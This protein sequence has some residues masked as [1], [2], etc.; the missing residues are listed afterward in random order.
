LV[1]T[2]SI[3]DAIGPVDYSRIEIKF[4]S[5]PKV[6]DSLLLAELSITCGLEVSMSNLEDNRRIISVRGLS[7]PTDLSTAFGRL[8]PRIA[9]ILGQPK[10]WSEGSPGV[11][12]M[13]VMVYLGNALKRERLVK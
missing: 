4:E 3:I 6:F 9:N 5:E 10:S 8:E 13:V 1:V 2:S 12:Q 7:T 11:V